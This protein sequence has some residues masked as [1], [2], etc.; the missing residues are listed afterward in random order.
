MRNALFLFIFYFFA[1]PDGVFGLLLFVGQGK[2]L[3]HRLP[4]VFLFKRGGNVRV[5]LETI[6]SAS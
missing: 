5:Q 3:F 4:V 2:R 1:G 6:K